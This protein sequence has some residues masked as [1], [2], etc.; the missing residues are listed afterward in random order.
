[1]DAILAADGVWPVEVNPRYTAS[2][3]TLERATGLRAIALHVAACR[4]L[5]VETPS[6][7]ATGDSPHCSG[8][9]ILFARDELTIA[10]SFV[11]WAESRNRGRTW[12]EVADIPAAGTRIGPGE[13]IA[14]VFA[15]AGDEAAVLNGLQAAAAEMASRAI[16]P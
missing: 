12:P 16:R 3:E 2:V 5:P 7:I 9:A 4:G 10:E 15:E 8:K 13:P 1:M 6:P 11:Q 14:T